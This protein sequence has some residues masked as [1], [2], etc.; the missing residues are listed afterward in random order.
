VEA[1][2]DELAAHLEAHLDVPALLGLAR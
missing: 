1:R 2:L